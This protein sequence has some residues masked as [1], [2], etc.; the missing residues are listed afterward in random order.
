MPLFQVASGKT[1]RVSSQQNILPCI[2]LSKN[3]LL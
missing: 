1:P 3:I 2:C